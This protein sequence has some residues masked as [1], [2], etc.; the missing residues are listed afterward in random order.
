MA[1]LDLSD[2]TFDQIQPN[3]FAGNQQLTDLNLK[4]CNLRSL[5]ETAFSHLRSLKFLDISNNFLTYIPGGSSLRRLDHLEMLRVGANQ[6]R[7]IKESDM[8][9][10]TNLKYLS[11]DG[12]RNMDGDRDSNNEF[13]IDSDA[14]KHNTELVQ[15]NIT[16][17]CAANITCSSIK[18]K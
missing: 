17:V 8:K 15:V 13:R 7:E 9:P 16:K 5:H 10:L 2:N 14:F 1:V 12:C 6:I 11:I 4:G 3:A 18:M